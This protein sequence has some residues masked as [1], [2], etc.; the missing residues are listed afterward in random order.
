MIAPAKPANLPATLTALGDYESDDN[1]RPLDYRLIVRLFRY[2]QPHAAK[3]NWLLV[4]VLLRAI[5]IPCLTWIIAAVI[6]GPV[7]DS[8]VHGLV[9]GASLFSVLAVFTQITMY[10]RQRLALELGEDVVHD[11]R[12][13]IFQHLQ[14][15]PLG[16]FNK[17]KVGRI[18]SRMISDVEDLR[19]GVQEV[20]F[21]TLVQLGQ[22]VVAAAFMLWYDGELFLLVLGLAPVLWLLNRHFHRR[23]SHAYRAIRDSFSRVTATLA[24]SVN[25]IRVTQG[26]ARQETNAQMFR[27]LIEDHSQYNVTAIRVQGLF[28]PLLDLNN[29]CFVAMLLLVGGYPGAERRQLD[30]RRR[31]GRVLL[32]GGDVLLADQR[33][34]RSI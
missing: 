25:G 12:N 33:D 7:A 15:M 18:I 26:F 5:Q 23:L 27:D 28:L 13:D 17:T 29:Q 22:M 16:Y 10:F 31:S 19:V 9:I 24:E 3:R 32:H 30:E 21:V 1:R 8:D 2:T 20:L 14:R 4:S 34:Q 6:K 11:L